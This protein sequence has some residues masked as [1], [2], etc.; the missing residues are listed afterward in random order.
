MR[1]KFC[2]KPVCSVYVCFSCH[3]FTVYNCSVICFVH[4]TEDHSNLKYRTP[5]NTELAVQKTKNWG[6]YSMYIHVSG[7]DTDHRKIIHI[8]ELTPSG[9]LEL[10]LELKFE[11][12]NEHNS[13]SLM[14]II[15]ELGHIFDQALAQ[16]KAFSLAAT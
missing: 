12:A 15:R 9:S 4:V 14:S 3:V 11:Y 16:W 5:K 13:S 2:I 6:L 1:I 8:M 7:A 10:D